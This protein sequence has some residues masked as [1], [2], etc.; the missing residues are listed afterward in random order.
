MPLNIEKETISYPSTVLPSCINTFWGDAYYKKDI[1]YYKII[2][3]FTKLINKNSTA[4]KYYSDIADF[5]F[6]ILYTEDRDSIW[7][8]YT[9]NDYSTAIKLEPDNYSYYC[10]RGIFYYFN[11]Q[12]EKAVADLTKS[13]NISTTAM[14]I[15][16]R[17]FCY[18]VLNNIESACEDYIN[19]IESNDTSKQQYIEIARESI[20]YEDLKNY[21]AHIFYKKGQNYLK[22]NKFDL[23]IS[24]FEEALKITN[25]KQYENALLE[26]KKLKKNLDKYAELYN[27]GFEYYYDGDYENTRNS[28]ISNFSNTGKS[29]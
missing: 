2:S 9:E 1:N 20:N 23:A 28:Y 24:D 13:I 14:A 10:K 3:D 5:Y 22:E 21:S 6:Y 29:F 27:L 11:E 26:A 18:E 15:C 7:L 12:Y 17:A 19:I 25:H 16:Y 4:S 8:E